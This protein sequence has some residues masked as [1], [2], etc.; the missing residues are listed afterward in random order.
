M[1]RLMLTTLLLSALPLLFAVSGY[2]QASDR[3]G[4]R[5]AVLRELERTDAVIERATEVSAVN[6]SPIT[7]KALESARSV[8]KSAREQFDA[9]NLRV[10]RQLTLEARQLAKQSLVRA[11]VAEHGQEEL[12]R[13]LDK[14][15][16]ALNRIDEDGV[17]D[18]NQVFNSLYDLTRENL[19]RAREFYDSQNYIASFRLLEQVERSIWRLSRVVHRAGR[20]FDQYENR[21]LQVSDLIDRVKE[22]TADCD[23]PGAR[24][25]IKQA[26]DSFQ[27]AEDFADK[28]QLRPALSALQRAQG[29]ANDAARKCLGPNSLEQIYTRLVNQTEKL[30]SQSNGTDESAKLLDQAKEQLRLARQY[31]DAHDLERA[32][33]ALRGAQ[34]ALRQAA[35][36]LGSDEF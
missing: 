23:D 15:E 20:G 26:E 10:A 9:D 12:A 32:S 21:A 7:M 24:D 27:R 11:Q 13:R 34:L 17:L 8:Q 16:D 29:L 22:Q 5:D 31:L 14:A 1:K 19:R 3:P 30:S 25:L 2:S 6:N 33:A 4:L 36:Y 35:D 28:D 18:N